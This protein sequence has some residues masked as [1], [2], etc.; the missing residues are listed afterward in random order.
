MG[1]HGTRPC[2]FHL[3]RLVFVLMLLA[4]LGDAAGAAESAAPERLNF[5]Y[6]AAGT[7]ATA[8]LWITQHIGAFKKYGLDLKPIYMAGGLAPLAI[9]AG[10]VQFAIMSSGVMIPPVLRGVDLVMI[11]GLSNF[12]NQALLVAPETTDGKQLKGKR[13]SIQRL[14]DLTHI[15][16]REAVKHLGLADSDLQYQQ[17]GGVPA[18]FAALQSGQVQG[19]VLS[20]PYIGRARRLGYRVLVNLSDLRIPFAGSS[21]VTTRQLVAT[22]RPV[23]LNLLKAFA[24]GIHFYKRER[25]ASIAIVERYIPGATKD[26]IGEAIDHYNRDLDERP[27]P[28]PEGIKTAL[29]LFAQQTPAAKG[30]DPERFIDQSLLRELERSGFFAALGGSG[31]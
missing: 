28:R 17:I 5:G 9:M 26:E 21:I 31:K 1:H 24:E 18:R 7:V 22:R 14:G 19:A 13:I 4:G 10:E 2:G 11:A 8:P 15:A 6:S 23:A 30:A 16:A 20:P 3:P 27:Y 29:D 12:I 25:E